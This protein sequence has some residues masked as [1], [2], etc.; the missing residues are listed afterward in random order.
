MAT[1]YYE[2]NVMLIFDKLSHFSVKYILW[3]KN[4]LI[5]VILRGC[6]NVYFNDTEEIV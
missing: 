5:E 1:D 6:N 3:Y 2:E 4:C